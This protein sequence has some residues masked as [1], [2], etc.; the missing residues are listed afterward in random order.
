MSICS[1]D[2]NFEL[3]LK[4][5]N[6]ETPTPQKT[7]A[8][9]CDKVTRRD[10]FKE[11]VRRF[12]PPCLLRKER[13]QGQTM[14]IMKLAYVIGLHVMRRGEGGAPTISRWAVLSQ[15]IINLICLLSIPPIAM[16]M[17]KTGY[18]WYKVMLLPY[19][20]GFFLCMYIYA[21]TIH[22]RYNL[23]TFLEAMAD[24]VPKTTDSTYRLVVWTYLYPLV[25]ASCTMILFFGTQQIEFTPSILVVSFVP[26]VLDVYMGSLGKV[27]QLAL[28]R[29]TEKVETQD[30]WTLDAARQVMEQWFHLTE[31]LNLYNKVRPECYA[32]V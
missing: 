25:I 32:H 7:V 17:F 23:L 3:S 2:K 29:L 21:R 19:A 30:A 1:T 27:L 24:M 8:E 13:K 4:K 16:V 20:F 12:L 22:H 31:L 5:E 18:F 6:S 11:V 26:A 14:H 10:K 28:V 15:I 9:S